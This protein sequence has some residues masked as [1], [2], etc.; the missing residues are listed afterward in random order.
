MQVKLVTMVEGNV[1][2]PF[3]ITTTPRCREECNSFSW[4]ALFYP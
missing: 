2:A 1:K 4:I 3:S